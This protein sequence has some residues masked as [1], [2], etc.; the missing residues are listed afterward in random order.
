MDNP[1]SSRKPQFATTTCPTCGTAVEFLLPN[2]NFL[3]SGQ[4]I[5]VSCYAC[6]FHISYYASGSSNVSSAT[7]TPSSNTPTNRKKFRIGTDEEPYSLEY[8]EVLGIGAQA[9]PA[10][11]KKAYYALA[12]RFHPDKCKTDDAEEK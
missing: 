12:M 4:P 1:I 10:E 6:T 11:I 5:K 7:H 8:Y 9:T 2:Q 3:S